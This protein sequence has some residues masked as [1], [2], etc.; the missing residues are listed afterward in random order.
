M[1]SVLDSPLYR[2]DLAKAASVFDFS[3]L[4]GK[5]ILITGAT[6]LIGAV[7]ADLCNEVG[8]QVFAAGRKTETVA[9]R[10]PYATPIA[11]DATKQNALD[12]AV[13]YVVA[14]ASNADPKQMMAHPVDTL[15]ANVSGTK[16]LLDYC[17]EKRVARFV[18][19]SSSE[20]YGK[21]EKGE[22]FSEQ[23]YG[24]V[25]LLNPRS[26]YPMGKR[27]AETLCASYASERGVD[28]TVV[29][30]GHIYGPTAREHDSRVSS[31]FSYAAA[32]G[33]DIVLKSA[34]ESVRSYCYGL[35]CAAAILFALLK[36]ESGQAYNIASPK[37]EI[38]IRDM[39][40]YLASAGGVSL[41]AGEV[42][43]AEKA[44]FNP[45][46]RSSLNGDKLQAL[47]WSSLFSPQEGLA[48][49]VQ[50]L[51]HVLQIST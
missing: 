45:M 39:A 14:G 19:L 5:K 28:F 41:T 36:G 6:G 9:E 31:V 48:R 10:F 21:Q 22:P 51:R 42:T 24:Y 46:T 44:A 37:M 16:E 11:Y 38:S 25:D 50:I 13:D 33:E 15:L 47:G 17:L 34:G 1:K 3:P 12:V 30:P 29:R 27:A 2:D 20:V 32:K 23:D 35:D 40:Q 4:V 18:Y 43:Q 7:L 49:T 26:C 8:A